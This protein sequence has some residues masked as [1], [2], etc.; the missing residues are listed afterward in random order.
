MKEVSMTTESI[1][2]TVESE[3]KLVIT[4]TQV[5]LTITAVWSVIAATAAVAL[6]YSIFESRYIDTQELIRTSIEV[7]NRV[8]KVAESYFHERRKALRTHIDGLTN[9][10]KDKDS[11]IQALERG[12][13]PFLLPNELQ[14]LKEERSELVKLIADS[15]SDLEQLENDLVFVKTPIEDALPIHF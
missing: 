7:N 13:Q 4:L 15:R 11:R 3:N 12:R 5:K 14:D 10:K 9:L 8:L 6:A 1:E 2:K